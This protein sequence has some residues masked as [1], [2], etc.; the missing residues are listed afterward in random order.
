MIK[1]KKILKESKYAW[2]RKFGDPL[3]T[4][5]D[6]AETHQNKPIKEKTSRTK[7]DMENSFET[8]ED[9]DDFITKHQSEIPKNQW[10]KIDNYLDDI[11]DEEQGMKSS[12]WAAPAKKGLKKILTRYIKES[13]N[14]RVDF[15]TI[16]GNKRFMTKTALPI[17]RKYGAK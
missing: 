6:I 1:L 11:R 10:R 14:E 9:L 17:I 3:P 2:D 7:R 4:F 16:T 12:G 8:S 15:H 5:K 13:I